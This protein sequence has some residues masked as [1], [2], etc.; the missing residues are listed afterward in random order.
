MGADIFPNVVRGEVDILK[1][2][3]LKMVRKQSEI[4]TSDDKQLFV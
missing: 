1:G 2:M 3:K 4:R